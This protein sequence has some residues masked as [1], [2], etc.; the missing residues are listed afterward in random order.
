VTAEAADLDPTSTLG[1]YRERLDQLT[2]PQEQAIID[3]IAAAG[4][5]AGCWFRV[6]DDRL[7]RASGA[8]VD[9]FV[10]HLRDRRRVRSLVDDPFPDGLDHSP[11]EGDEPCWIVISQQC[12]LLASMT[13]EP[14]VELARAYR[15]DDKGKAGNWWVNSSRLFPLDPKDK[16]W[17]IDLRHRGSMPKDQLRELGPALQALPRD[18]VQA[19]FKPRRRFL[20]R[21]G[22]RY[23][24]AAIPNQLVDDLANPLYNDVLKKYAKLVDLLFHDW[25]LHRPVGGSKPWLVA[26]AR[27]KADL[28]DRAEVAKLF[29]ESGLK[30]APYLR[31]EVLGLDGYAGPLETDMSADEVASDIF[32]AL[33]HELPPAALQLIDA[34]RS[35]A[36]GA[37][38]F[39]I[40]EF[41]DCWKLDFD[42]LSHS[43]QSD[44]T[45]ARSL[46]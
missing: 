37:D 30:I 39:S 7:V 34:H 31:E 28:L 22:H 33:L 2:E 26:L 27:E 9:S 23:S 35:E 25:V 14:F 12:D 6:D 13:E 5:D 36:L 40:V 45:S 19:G 32:D 42:A 18:D 3:A 24:R 44:E 10:D 4:W 21:V 41:E 1:N 20:R 11:I 8:T 46:Q 43:K 17:V 29:D 15:Y 16:S 38:S